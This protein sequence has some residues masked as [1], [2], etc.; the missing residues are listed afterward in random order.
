MA[1][2]YTAAVCLGLAGALRRAGTD[3]LGPADK[4][5]LTRSTLVGCV[6][7]LIADTV[8]EPAPVF[9]L[10]ALTLV[11]L[12]LDGLDGR[13]AR[14]TGTVSPLGAR[15]DMEVDA[16]LILVLSCYVA[17]QVGPWVLA[18]GFMRYVFVAAG[19]PLAWLRAPVPATRAGKLV[20]VIQGAVLLVA[21]AGV[22]PLV[23]TTWAVAGA[24][25]SLVWSFGRSVL[26][27][28]RNH[29]PV[30]GPAVRTH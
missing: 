24:L 27:L 21:C 17:V 26:W 16:F 9:L 13:V 6:T 18:I 28:Y 25:A 2:G 23:V 22:L 1:I 29:S 3:S 12:L 15:F 14:H 4:V 30:T 10:S 8:H 11:A 7:A 5:T 20:A 19:R